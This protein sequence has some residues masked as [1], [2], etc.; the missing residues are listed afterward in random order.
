MWFALQHRTNIVNLHHSGLIECLKTQKILET[1]SAYVTPADLLNL[2]RI[3]S[4]TNSCQ[5][6][7]KTLKKIVRK[8]L[9]KV[10]VRSFDM[11]LTMLS[12][13]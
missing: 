12:N 13:N 8:N 6:I 9:L 4:Q 10:L 11:K 2:C 1:L 3:S 7:K 5:Q